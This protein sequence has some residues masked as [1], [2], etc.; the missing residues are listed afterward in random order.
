[1]PVFN[2]ISRNHVFLQGNENAAAS[3][4]YW[5]QQLF[6][7]PDGYSVVIDKE[8]SSP[9]NRQGLPTPCI[10][11]NQLDTSDPGRG[12]M[13]A[14]AD[15]NGCLFYVYCLVDKNWQGDVSSSRLLRRMK[16]QVVF[17][18]KR[19]GMFDEASGDIVVPPIA[20]LNF[21]HN[22]PQDTSSTLLLNNNIVQHYTDDGDFIQYELVLSFRYTMDNKLSGA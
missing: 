4:Y 18:V 2:K 20:L 7:H 9:S 16:D 10:A 12:F 13:N 11:V 17:A 19:A 15:Q 3:F 5:L 8:L 1:M 22:P 6:D 14:D 21:A